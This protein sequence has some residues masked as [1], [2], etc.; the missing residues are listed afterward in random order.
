MLFPTGPASYGEPLMSLWMT[1]IAANTLKARIEEEPVSSRIGTGRNTD[2]RGLPRFSIQ[3][4]L[5]SRIA[6]GIIG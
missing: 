6:H 2:R 5:E 4:L 1:F 3:S